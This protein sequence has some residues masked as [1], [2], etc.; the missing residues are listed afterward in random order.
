MVICFGVVG[1]ALFLTFSFSLVYDRSCVERFA[2]EA[3]ILV[4]IAEPFIFK[5]CSS[6]K[7]KSCTV[8]VVRMRSQ[9]VSVLMAEA[10]RAVHV[11]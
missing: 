6:A 5:K 1:P 2:Y 8:R 7:E 4:S 9:S 11:Y 10:L 3:A